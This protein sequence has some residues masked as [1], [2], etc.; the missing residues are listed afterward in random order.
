MDSF[1]QLLKGFAKVDHHA[2]IEMVRGTN[3][4]WDVPNQTNTLLDLNYLDLEQSS[5]P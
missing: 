1:S 4:S 2:M 3:N 5:Q